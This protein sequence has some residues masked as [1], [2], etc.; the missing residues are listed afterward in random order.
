MCVQPYQKEFQKFRVILAMQFSEVIGQKT[1]ADKLI[2][3]FKNDKVAHAQLFIGK[4]G[5]G[6]LPLAL[7]FARYLLCENPQEEDSCG[8]CAS[9][10]KV[11]ILQHADLH[12]SFPMVQSISKTS[13]A[14]L[15]DW[16]EIIKETP[17]FDLND[18][19][20]K[21]DQKER[22]PIISV[23]ES[24]ELIRKLQ[25]RSHEGGRKILIMWMASEMNT[26]CSNK[27][28]KLIEEPP[29]DTIIILVCESEEQLLQTINSR[30]QNV[31]IPRINFESL[32]NA[33]VLR[34]VG[35]T[36]AESVASRCEGD[37][38]EANRLLQSDADTALNKDRF[39]QL[40][41]V[42]YKK[43]VID[44][45]RWAEEI[46]SEGREQQ[47]VFIKYALY[48]FR[49]SM[50]KNYTGNQLMRASEDEENFLANFSVFISGNNIL[51]LTNRFNDAHYHI[52][53]NANSRILFM[54]LCFKVMRLIHNA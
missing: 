1:I 13:D 20:K 42:C 3:E 31:V 26:S 22:R 46:A 16:R 49:Q 9:C 39:I 21:I 12:F 17:Y 45:M 35:K 37:M 28:L 2:L 51:E 6:G 40:M 27:L 43:N 50:M 29:K 41:R 7:A 36:S 38:I 54:N 10:H 15:K 23:D 14:M 18:W 34:K 30:T 33:L 11:E 44:M 47:K 53:R 25:L 8:T 4:A 32:V 5:Y 52:D 24:Q 48:M 19:I